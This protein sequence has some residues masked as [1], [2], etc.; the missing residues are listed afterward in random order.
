MLASALTLPSFSGDF[1]PWHLE[2]P[3]PDN[4][5][6][7][8]IGQLSDSGV[9]Q[10]YSSP[11]LSRV[12]VY[13]PTLPNLDVDTTW[14]HLRVNSS[15]SEAI[16]G[17]R[18]HA[19][20]NARD[21]TQ[22]EDFGTPNSRSRDQQKHWGPVRNLSLGANSM[23]ICVELDRAG[24]DHGRTCKVLNKV[25]D[26]GTRLQSARA[27]TRRVLRNQ[28]KAAT[29]AASV[30]RPWDAG[31]SEFSTSMS[32]IKMQCREI[33]ALSCRQV[34]GAA[35]SNRTMRTTSRHK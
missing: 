4:R 12:L 35:S 5:A 15:H 6:Y 28:P 33:I 29:A 3:F 8:S 14:R 26:V 24:S 31:W 13:N 30:T 34:Q 11:S 32:G 17:N 9:S 7:A 1:F 25:Y 18:L 16:R 21:C 19:P 22:C 23:R 10:L 2:Q 27:E 20:L